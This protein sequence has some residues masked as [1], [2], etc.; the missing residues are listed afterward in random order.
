MRAS[1]TTATVSLQPSSSS[2]SRPSTDSIGRPSS[3]GGSDRTRSIAS[4]PDSPFCPVPLRRRFERWS[5]IVLL[6]LGP[7]TSLLSDRQAVEQLLFALQPLGLVD[8]S[9][10]VFE[11]ELQQLTANAAFVVK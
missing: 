6:L 8:V 7:G 9:V 3:S 1:S 10:L 4:R 11:L 5:A 2:R